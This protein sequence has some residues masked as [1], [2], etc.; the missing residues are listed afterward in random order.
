MIIEIPYIFLQAVLFSAITYPTINFPWTL[1]KGFWY[2]YAM[3]CTLLYFSYFGIL[4]A[5]LTPTFQVAMVLASFCYTMFNLFSGFLVPGPV[6]QLNLYL[7]DKK[8]NCIYLRRILTILTPLAENSKMVGLGILDLPRSVVL[9]R[10][11]HFAVWRSKQG[12]SSTWGGT[13]HQCLLRKYSWVLLWW[14]EICSNCSLCI[15]IS[16]RFCFWGCYRET[17]LSEEVINN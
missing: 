13:D 11:S 3:F 16:F 10:S 5:A 15:S 12:D 1:Y 4:L 17:K 8:H 7:L 6:S 2:V 9:K 14:T